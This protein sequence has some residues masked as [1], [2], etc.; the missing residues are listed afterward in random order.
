[1]LI[2]VGSSVA[3]SRKPRQ[4]H[5]RA[6]PIDNVDLNKPGRLRVGHLMTLFSISH[7]TLYARLRSG[8]LPAPDG[9]DGARPYWSTA[10]I[11]TA[12]EG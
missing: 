12:L 6:A 8:E 4:T 9:K 1:M 5:A 10:T 2:L 11:R 3:S 7:S